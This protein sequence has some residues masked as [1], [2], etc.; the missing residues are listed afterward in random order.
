MLKDIRNSPQ[1]AKGVQILQWAL[2]AV[3]I[4]VIAT[5]I[6][7]LYKSFKAGSEAAG[8]IAGSGIIQQQ[9]GITPSRQVVC[10]SV[11]V[12]CENAITRI[13]LLGT[14]VWVSDDG[15]VNGL[16]RLQTAEEAA[17]TSAFFK[18]ATGSSL[19]GVVEGGWFAAVNRNKINPIVRNYLT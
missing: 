8:D 16:N 19:K 15:I 13:P 14:I 2:V 12:D 4:L 5:V 17:L 11:A 6:T 9:T 3:I 1:G 10:K 7:K 18:Q